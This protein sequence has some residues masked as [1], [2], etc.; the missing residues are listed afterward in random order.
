MAVNIK[1]L[2]SS[3]GVNVRGANQQNTPTSVARINTNQSR[4]GD[5]PTGHGELDDRLTTLMGTQVEPSVINVVRAFFVEVPAEN[6]L[7]YR[8]MEIKG[9][10]TT[11]NL[12][13]DTVHSL[14]GMVTP[15]S[16]RNVARDI[17]SPTMQSRGEIGIASSWGERRFAFFIMFEERTRNLVTKSVIT[18]YTDH[19]GA[20]MGMNNRAMFE[21]NMKL[22][23]TSHL[24]LGQ[25]VTAGGRFQGKTNS[26]LKTHNVIRPV[27]IRTA[28]Q[29]VETVGKTLRPTDV[30]SYIAGMAIDPN[31]T[32]T[33]N[34]AGLSNS[35]LGIASDH[36]NEIPSQYLAKLV[37]SSV[38]GNSSMTDT[39]GMMFADSSLFNP[40]GAAAGFTRE[41]SLH[42]S[43]LMN[44]ILARTS[45][46]GGG[47]A[48]MNELERLWPNIINV[49]NI[50]KLDTRAVADNRNVGQD[51]SVPS[52]STVIAHALSHGIPAMM[53]TCMLTTI[54]FVATN[55]TNQGM[56]GYAIT[57][58]IKH[59]TGMFEDDA[60][61][62]RK[63]PIYESCIAEDV[64]TEMFQHGE[65]FLIEGQFTLFGV[66]HMKISVN[67]EVSTP[68]T[69]PNYAAALNS[70][71][72]IAN[73]REGHEKAT[74]AKQLIDNISN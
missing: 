15:G 3:Q 12:L 60:T 43:S 8:P 17:I 10:A 58:G 28:G 20:G 30:S 56:G 67:G 42:S 65:S 62:A 6:A 35:E 39:S 13:K 23:I 36:R 57:V 41:Y 54:D 45:Y 7:Q 22:Y 49:S 64:L 2:N 1:T 68:F 27:N 40:A 24:N 53:N 47:F 63:T 19:V 55:Q 33:G 61:L 70:G 37:R 21:Q 26:Q 51:W 9:D 52:R 71:V 59:A 18:G 31:I 4:G 46:A 11:I 66:S 73:D 69:Y 32:V 25:T 29:G 50:H 16:V 5:V 72:L 38:L 14:G 34:D 48:Y 44:E 74:Y